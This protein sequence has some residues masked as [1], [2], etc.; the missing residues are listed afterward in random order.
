MTLLPDILIKYLR[1]LMFLGRQTLEDLTA[2]AEPTHP[3]TPF[4]PLRMAILRGNV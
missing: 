2:E 3:P 4:F 1:Y